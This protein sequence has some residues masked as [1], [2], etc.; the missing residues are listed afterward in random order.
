MR[1]GLALSW[2]LS[3][4]AIALIAVS[5]AIGESQFGLFLIFPFV[6]GSGP[7]AIAGAVLLFVAVVT[8]FVSFMR[9]LPE[10]EDSQAIPSRKILERPEK[11]YG[12]VVMIG[13]VPIAFGSDSKIAKMMMIIGIIVFIAIVTMLILS[14]VF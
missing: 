14:V 11:R 8:M 10:P 12:G 6:I 3:S 1:R 2:L 9:Q 4:L 5:V 7:I 13:P